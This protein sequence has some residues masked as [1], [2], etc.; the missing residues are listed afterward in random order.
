MH[1]IRIFADFKRNY[2]E[3]SSQCKKNYLN[4]LGKELNNYP[5]IEF[6]DDDSY[7]HAI[8]INFAK[9]KLKPN[10]PKDNVL[11]LAFEP[12]EFLFEGKFRI[13]F[14]CIRSSMLNRVIEEDIRY[15]KANIGRYL[16]G[17][18]KDLPLPFEEHYT[19]MWHH[20]P[21]TSPFKKQED[22]PKLMSLM[23]SGKNYTY[24][25]KYRRTL[26]EEIL[27]TDLPIDIW[28]SGCG[29]LL[30]DMRVKG[31]FKEYEP[32]DDYL[33]TIAIENCESNDYISEKYCDPLM[34]NCI[35]L[36]WGAKNIDNY[37][38]PNWGYRL[39]GVLEDDMDLIRRICEDPEFYRI[40]LSEA[41]NEKV[42]G[43]AFLP[44]F[45]REWC[46]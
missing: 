18:K 38:G 30:D 27:K 41:Y 46:G 26:A 24:G 15:I 7:T 12:Y 39:T 45:L 10:F 33:F 4:V 31:R 13:H 2:E 3:T 23:V 5:E 8:I 34:S 29:K 22:K 20:W 35:P 14:S 44:N 32:F 40:D 19:F 36:Y 42:K 17:L 16:I 37:F 6:V 1:K 9:P 25:H 43:K 28:G 21:S 11:G